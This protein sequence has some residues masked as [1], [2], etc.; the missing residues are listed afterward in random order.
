MIN[1][2]NRQVTLLFVVSGAID[3]LLQ[4]SLFLR[5]FSVQLDLSLNVLLSFFFCIVVG[6]ML[7]TEGGHLAHMTLFDSP[8]HAM[9]K[10]TFYFVIIVLVL[11]DI[12][13]ARYR[14]KLMAMK[15]AVHNA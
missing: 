15:A 11:T 9:T 6:I 12:V 8:V 14:K 1:T 5:G 7:I 3:W 2:V 13:Q 10:T 4:V